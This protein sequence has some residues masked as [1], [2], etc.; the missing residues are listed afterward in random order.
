MAALLLPRHLSGGIHMAHHIR[1][2][3]GELLSAE[4]QDATIFGADDAKVGQISDVLASGDVIVDVGGFLGIGSKT[5]AIPASQLEFMRY[6]HGEI[7]AITSWTKEDLMA[8]P[9]YSG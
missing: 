3:E 1:L 4:F 9:E 5:L 2:T 8:M 7:Y 6:E